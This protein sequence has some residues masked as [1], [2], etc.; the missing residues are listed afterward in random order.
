MSIDNGVWASC[1]LSFLHWN[2]I[3]AIANCT[4]MSRLREVT[5][6]AIITGKRFL[7]IRHNTY[8]LYV[9][10]Y[11]YWII[12]GLIGFQVFVYILKIILYKKQVEFFQDRKT[13][14]STL[15]KRAVAV[16][17]FFVISATYD[18]DLLPSLSKKPNWFLIR[19]WNWIYPF[20]FKSAI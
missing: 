3:D 18:N 16:Q 2:C 1:R 13:Y 4:G 12:C 15:K 8:I 17:T 9:C 14:T 11:V 5:Y 20:T 10:T 7:T 19:V 6:V